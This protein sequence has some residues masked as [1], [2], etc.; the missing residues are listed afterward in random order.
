MGRILGWLLAIL[1]VAGVGF[2]FYQRNIAA[3]PVVATDLDK[4]GAYSDAEKASLKAACAD[5]FKT[6]TDKVC[7]CVADKAGTDFSRFD[8]MIL[9]ATMQEKVSEIVGITKGLIAS[10]IDPAKM[11]TVEADARQRV[12]DLI[13]TCN[14][15]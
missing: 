9:T 8:R 10:G 15:G 3:V 4:G 11:K 5:H 14:P 7:G 1:V 12:T 2:Y 6:N 13:K